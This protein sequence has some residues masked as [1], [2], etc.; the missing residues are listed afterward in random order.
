MVYSQRVRLD[1]QDGASAYLTLPNQ[2]TGTLIWVFAHEISPKAH[3]N[4]F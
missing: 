4:T 1:F 3:N 2:E